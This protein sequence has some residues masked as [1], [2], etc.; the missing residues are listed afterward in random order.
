MPR[1]IYSQVV[2]WGER[3]KTNRLKDIKTDR[4]NSR[5]KTRKER[6]ARKKVPKK[7]SH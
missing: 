1:A 3:E 5:K 6:E 2:G 7:E 4:E